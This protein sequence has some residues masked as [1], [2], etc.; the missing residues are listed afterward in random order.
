VATAS[1][2]QVLR[3]LPSGDSTRRGAP[4]RA[5]SVPHTP[6]DVT[7]SDSRGGVWQVPAV[8][9][10]ASLLAAQPPALAGLWAH[11]AACAAHYQTRWLRWPRYVWGCVHTVFAGLLRVAEWVTDSPPKL[12]AAAAVAAACWYWS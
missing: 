9:T 2:G 7:D 8:L 10:G 12:L 3:D 4:R 5:D 11:H 1:N 6:P